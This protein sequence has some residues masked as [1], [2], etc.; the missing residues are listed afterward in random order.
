[1]SIIS[2]T[3]PRNDSF[4][5]P[6]E[7]AAHD[8]T[9]MI[10][11]VR[12]G[13]WGKDRTGTLKSFGQIFLEI[14]RRE[15]LYLLAGKNHWRE[16]KDFMD[17][18]IA[19]NASD[20]KEIELLEN[21]CLIFPI[22]SDD[23]WARDV[24]PTFVVNRDESFVGNNIRGINWKFNAWGGEVD[25][26]YASWDRDD[27]VAANFCD[28]CDIAFYDAD[29]FVLEGGSIHCDGEG[30]V[31]VTEACLL[32]KGRNPSLNRD[33]IEENLKKYLGAEKVLWLP[34]GIYNDETNEHVDNVCA[35]VAPGEVVLAW[36]D[37]EDDPQYELSKEDLEY[38]E[39]ITD[40]KGR[41]LIIH[42]LP[43]PDKPVLVTEEDL[44]NYEFEEGED[45][46]DIGE[47]LAASYVNFYFINGAALVPQFGGE[48]ATSDERALVLLRT[49]CPDREIIGIP[50]RDILLG[51]GN[52]HC[53]TQQI[54]DNNL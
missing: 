3:F 42:R 15:N 46:R 9:I 2:N 21:R 6:A 41:K 8:G 47:R 1:M 14:L 25:G 24:G 27:K 13:S 11:P 51:G 37:D 20:Q 22:D 16:A 52:I 18:L 31:M 7:Y 40:A 32:S 30:T 33:Q 12:P 35:F 34:R 23:A 4:F 48:N 39:S 5:M 36:T 10:F 28:S 38:L 45:V 54:P 17:S 50:A 29:P 44:D 26:L 49:I 43:I 53:I 19:H